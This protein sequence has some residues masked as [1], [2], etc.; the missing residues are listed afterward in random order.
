MHIMGEYIFCNYFWGVIYS[1]GNVIINTFLCA[2][3][4]LILK[5]H[6]VLIV[7]VL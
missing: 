6:K 4:C 5:V 7:R 1:M 3:S 2:N